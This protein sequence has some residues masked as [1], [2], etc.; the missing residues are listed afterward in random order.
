MD[1][2]T[3]LSFTKGFYDQIRLFWEISKFYCFECGESVELKTQKLPGY[4]FKDV[5]SSD[6]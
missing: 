2:E 3:K 1:L 5:T 6:Y 4:F